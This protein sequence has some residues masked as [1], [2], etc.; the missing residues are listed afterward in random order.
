MCWTAHREQCRLA[1]VPPN[2]T[3][4]NVT[5]NISAL[6]TAVFSFLLCLP[7]VA[8]IFDIGVHAFYAA[9]VGHSELSGVVDQP[10]ARRG[11]AG[12]GRGELCRRYQFCLRKSFSNPQTAEVV[13]IVR[14]PHVS[15]RW[16]NISVIV[17]VHSKCHRL[18]HVSSCFSVIVITTFIQY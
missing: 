10:P 9:A 12:A 13:F 15:G 14:F 11:A 4:C 16:C 3:Y 8:L 2:R 5:G 6:F 1:E 17:S 7:P 18:T